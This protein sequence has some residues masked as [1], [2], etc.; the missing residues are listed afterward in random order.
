MSETITTM[1]VEDR[2]EL[3]QEVFRPDEIHNHRVAAGVML[4][5]AQAEELTESGQVIAAFAQGMSQISNQALRAESSDQLMAKIRQLLGTEGKFQAYKRGE[6]TL[7]ELA[8][9][10]I[11][12]S[13]IVVTPQGLRIVEIEPGKVRGLGYGVLARMQSAHPVGIGAE[14]SLGRLIADQPTA[15]ILSE[16]DRFHEPE[17]C[18]LAGAVAGLH[19]RT[20]RLFMHD[21][22]RNPVEGLIMMSPLVNSF[23]VTESSVREDLTIVSDRRLDL[24]SKGAFAL[25]H[26]GSQIP[27]LEQLLCE[28]FEPAMLARLRELVPK[29]EH[30]SLD[31][32]LRERVS[33]TGNDGLFLKPV[34]ESGTRGIITP[35]NKEEFAAAIAKHKTLAKFMVQEAVDTVLTPMQ[36][37]DVRSGTEHEDLM[38]LRI[39]VHVDKVGNIIESTV[40]GSPHAFLAH[41]GKTS[42]ITNLEAVA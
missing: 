29:A 39:T 16:K 28:T 12:K 30:A 8:E 35:D 31:D 7:D 42:V 2:R 40:V 5:S 11:T 14:A 20:Q 6:I 3:V 22:E 38:N 19:S 23:G 13:D 17:I 37:L 4:E 15:V 21:Q 33:Q 27:E 25:L 36:S 10:E 24:E 18:L 32:S 41:G 1:S 34:L 26:N 9:A